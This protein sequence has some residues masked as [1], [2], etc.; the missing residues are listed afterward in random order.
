MVKKETLNFN[1]RPKFRS[2]TM[3]VDYNI[4]ILS[5][6]REGLS[7]RFF[8][9]DSLIFLILIYLKVGGVSDL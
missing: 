1:N 4:L 9:L 8:K 6:H 2:L 7:S 3:H 5:T